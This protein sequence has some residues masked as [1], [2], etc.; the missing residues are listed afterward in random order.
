MVFVIFCRVLNTNISS[1]YRVLRFI[2]SFL[3]SE[4]FGKDD[5]RRESFRHY[6]YIFII[7][8]IVIDIIIIIIIYLLLLFL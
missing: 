3:C 5:G 4:D 2:K 6:L 7:I 1:V 8:I